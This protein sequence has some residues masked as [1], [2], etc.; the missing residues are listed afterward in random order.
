[1][2]E[3]KRR[4]WGATGSG[5]TVREAVVRP[6][7]LQSWH[8]PRLAFT[9]AS[10]SKTLRGALSTE[11]EHARVQVGAFGQ[12]FPLSSGNTG[13]GGVHAGSTRLVVAAWQIAHSRRRQIEAPICI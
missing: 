4:G 3:A 13:G 12:P 10:I 6:T 5:E 2:R 7:S 8:T 9:H 1:M 11:G